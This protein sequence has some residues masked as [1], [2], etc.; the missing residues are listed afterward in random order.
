MRGAFPGYIYISGR[1]APPVS[2]AAGCQM[3]QYFFTVRASE[4]DPAE[5]TAELNDNAAALAYACEIIRELMQSLAGTDRSLYVKVRDETLLSIP[6]PCGVSQYKPSLR[7]RIASFRQAIPQRTVCEAFSD[8]VHILSRLAR[9]KKNK[10]LRLDTDHHFDTATRRRTANVG[11]F[12]WLE[13][14]SRRDVRHHSDH[15]YYSGLDGPNIATINGQLRR[16][17]RSPLLL[18]LGSAFLSYFCAA[19]A[20]RSYASHFIKKTAHFSFLN[21]RR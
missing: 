8:L 10:M 1:H 19:D 16:A 21:H 20:S 17:R 15:R 12:K 6:V 4:G 9:N 7:P 3:P 14:L 11:L 13:L 5:R 2:R 18:F